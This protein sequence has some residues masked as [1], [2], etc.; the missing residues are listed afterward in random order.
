MRA[1]HSEPAQ[2]VERE[3]TVESATRPPQCDCRAGEGPAGFNACIAVGSVYNGRVH[4][5]PTVAESPSPLNSPEQP[6]ALR[7]SVSP[8]LLVS[9]GLGNILGAGIYV[10]VGKVAGAAGMYAP[11]AFLIASVLATFSAFSYAELSARYPFS[12]GE[13]V[14]VEHGFGIRTLSLSVGLAI[15]FAGSLACAAMI[16]G[17]AGYLQVLVDAPTAMAILVLVV[18][19]GSV[20]VYGI[21]Q[22]V[23]LAAVLT[24]AEVIGLLLI[25]WSGRH[26][27]PQ[28]SDRL[29]ELLPTLDGSIWH[30]ILA[31]SLLAFYAYLG[32]EDMVNVAE[33]VQEPT[34]NMPIAILVT[35]GLATLMYMIVT[36]VAVLSL[37]P[38]TLAAGDAPLAMIYEQN[39]GRSPVAITVI[40]MSAVVNGALIQIIMT[41]RVLYGLSRRGW[42]P[43]PLGI[44]HPTTRTPI[45]ATVLVCAGIAALALS[46][47]MAQLAESTGIVILIVFTL[48]NLSLIRIR[49]R[50]PAPPGLLVFPLWIP[51]L[52]FLASIS[53]VA[54]RLYGFLTGSG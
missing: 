1:G 43:E 37:P 36:L 18:V 40:G 15:V 48:V 52:G 38:Q 23:G 3:R 46:M 5:I 29:P 20:A 39:T 9:Y 8:V 6:V 34:R 31:G 4:A 17:F 12:A 10:L 24:V 2:G 45:I 16:Q 53:F 44:V 19:L 28:F 50:E 11:I 25:I 33:E 30:G 49:R 21:G 13:S 51:A 26:T 35:L 54:Y 47:E 22:S 41:S 32:F 14:Y 27:L 42:L 7:R